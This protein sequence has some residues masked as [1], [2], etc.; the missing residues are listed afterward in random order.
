[1]K[2]RSLTA[3]QIQVKKQLEEME[4]D[5]SMFRRMRIQEEE[6]IKKQEGIAIKNQ[7]ITNGIQNKKEI[8]DTAPTLK[9]VKEIIVWYHNFS[10]HMGFANDDSFFKKLLRGFQ[11]KNKNV[12]EEVHKKIKT[13]V[14]GMSP[15]MQEKWRQALPEIF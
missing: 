2:N 5:I 11:Q 9:T 13:Q 8:E 1:M 3:E 6:K 10:H 12:K 15:D 7:L 14:F 4:K